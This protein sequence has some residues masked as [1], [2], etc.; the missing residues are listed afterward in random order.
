MKFL[1]ICGGR[2]AA[3]LNGSLVVPTSPGLDAVSVYPIPALLMESP[4]NT[5]TPLAALTVV[6]PESV[7]PPGLD[8]IAMLTAF[9]AVVAVLPNAS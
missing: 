3:T 8:P 7:P 9:V 4:L 6:V 5:A 1:T 2:A